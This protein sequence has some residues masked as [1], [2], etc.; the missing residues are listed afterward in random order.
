MIRLPSLLSSRQPSPQP[1]PRPLIQGPLIPSNPRRR[2]L[3]DVGWNIGR[4]NDQDIVIANL[5]IDG[6]EGLT[7]ETFINT[8]SQRP[9]N[10]QPYNNTNTIIILF[11]ISLGSG[12]SKEIIKPEYFDISNFRTELDLVAAIE[13]YYSQD[14]SSNLDPNLIQILNNA[15][16]DFSN[17]QIVG[18]KVSFLEETLVGFN[19]V[20]EYAPGVYYVVYY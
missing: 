10:L 6:E 5:V 18:Q 2:L 20:I 12:D 15:N 8:L 19:G 3:S 14:I 1:S 13:N 4:L 17:R 11:P 16:F 7:Q 9:I